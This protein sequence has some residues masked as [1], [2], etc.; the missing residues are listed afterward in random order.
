LKAKQNLQRAD[1]ISIVEVFQ[2]RIS[3][4]EALVKYEQKKSSSY[5]EQHTQM[6]EKVKV[7][8]LEKKMA[9]Q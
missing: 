7:A 3:D 5:I 8:K 2:K 9:E 6:L 4:M 1:V